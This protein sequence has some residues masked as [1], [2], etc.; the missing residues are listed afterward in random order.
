MS[1][2]RKREHEEGRPPAATHWVWAGVLGLIFG[3]VYYSFQ[4][5]TGAQLSL[6]GTSSTSTSIV[7]TELEASIVVQ[8]GIQN[9]KAGNDQRFELMLPGKMIK[10]ETV[11][12]GWRIDEWKSAGNLRVIPPSPDGKAAILTDGGRWN[13]S[14][15]GGNGEAYHDPQVIGKIDD[16]HAFVVATTNIR[17]IFIV[18]RTGEIRSLIE[19]PEFANALFSEDGHL[20]LATYTPG[21]GIESEPSGPSRLIRV[22]L[23]GIQKAI[24]QETKVITSVL[25]GPE[26]AVAYRTETW[27]RVHRENAGLGMACL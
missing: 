1:R 8:L 10:E 25:P 13:V 21:Q 3:G 20:W 24:A 17:S 7:S 11:E 2:R 18:S 9:P 19:M 26:G 22:S 23:S 15:R 12:K 16:T 4:N 5:G 27:L 14:L 6:G